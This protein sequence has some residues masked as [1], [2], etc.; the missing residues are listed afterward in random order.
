MEKTSLGDKDQNQI[1]KNIIKVKIQTL[2]IR[3]FQKNE[4]PQKISNVEYH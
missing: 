2:I 4:V 3:I 1:Q